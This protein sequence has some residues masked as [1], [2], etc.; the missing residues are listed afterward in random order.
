[1]PSTSLTHKSP[2]A[3]ERGYALLPVAWRQNSWTPRVRVL[4]RGYLKR[5]AATW[6]FVRAEWTRAAQARGGARRL[7]AGTLLRPQQPR[8]ALQRLLSQRS[9]PVPRRLQVMFRYP[10]HSQSL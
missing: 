1:M 5:G 2:R 10:L 4:R 8:P 9:L 7:P 6:L 3:L